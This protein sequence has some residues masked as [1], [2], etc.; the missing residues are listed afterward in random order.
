[1]APLSLLE[2][3][4]FRIVPV[5][6]IADPAKAVPLAEALTDGGLPVA[7][8]TLRTSTALEAIRIIR[9]RLPGFLVGA[10]SLLNA[11]QVERAASAGAVFGVSPGLTP[12][13]VR[14]A[15]RLGL[16][17]VPGI[18][19]V[20]EVLQALDL[21]VNRLKFFPSSSLGGIATVRAFAAPLVQTEARFMPTGGISPENLAE[22][23]AVPAVFAV[24]GSWIA[25]RSQI[26]AGDF[27]GI[28]ERARRAVALAAHVEVPTAG[29]DGFDAPAAIAEQSR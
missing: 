11:N 19:T 9:D 12:D 1:M 2:L 6:E 25:T 18:A 8:I 17:F 22:Y 5:V 20:S 27:A 3:E 13:T 15:G 16:P 21:G 23:L 14:T 7:E 4:Q 24:G 29:H 26:N 10:G 28:T